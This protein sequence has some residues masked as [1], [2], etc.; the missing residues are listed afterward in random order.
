MTNDFVFHFIII[1]NDL[2]IDC[3]ICFISW[4][5]SWG[6]YLEFNFNY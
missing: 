4:T 6:I 1:F 2:L 5:K 3:Y